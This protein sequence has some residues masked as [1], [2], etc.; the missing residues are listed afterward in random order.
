[1]SPLRREA[2]ARMVV[3]SAECVEP[4]P[5][6]PLTAAP[7]PESGHGGLGVLLV[8]GFMV[9]E[10]HIAG[11]RCGE[12]VGPG[13]V[14][15][16]WSH[17][18]LSATVPSRVEWTVLQRATIARLDA[19]FLA[20]AARWPEVAGALTERAVE[21]AQAT[22]VALAIVRI[23]GLPNRILALLWTLADRFGRVTPDGVRLDIP[24]THRVL[25]CLAGASR[26]WVTMALRTLER[27]GLVERTEDRGY[28]LLG[29]S[30]PVLP[31]PGAA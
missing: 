3:A 25:A 28:L 14:L 9:R 11:A 20:C 23:T 21:R 17:A 26:S 8:E 29:E 18:G 27:D 30:Q 7:E 1:M 10:V 2:A 22:G 31:A 6:D 19:A 12:L 15:R 16:P 13:D 5:W 24:L 4:G